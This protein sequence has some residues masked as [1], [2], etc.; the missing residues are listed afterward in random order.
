MISFEP[1]AAQICS[2]RDPVTEVA[3]ERLAQGGELAIRV[4]VHGQHGAGERL[5]DVAGD[6]L[7]DRMGVLVDVQRVA[8]VL[9]RGAVRRQAAEVVTD[10]QIGEGGHPRFY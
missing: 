9:L 8:H 3:G 6:R 7:R 10:R 1:F 2:G 4:P 5:D